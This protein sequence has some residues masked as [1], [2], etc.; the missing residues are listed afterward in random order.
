MN[1]IVQVLP[2]EPES[3]IHLDMVFTLLDNDKCL[4]YPPV[5]FNQHAF[6]TVHISIKNGKVKK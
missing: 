3:F 2:R 4:I 6:E 5:I 1:I